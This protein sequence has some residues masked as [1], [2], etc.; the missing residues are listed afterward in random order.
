MQWSVQNKLTL[1]F[2]KTK[3]MIFHGPGP[4]CFIVPPPPVGIECVTSFKLLGVYL[5]ST[6]SMENHVN[7]FFC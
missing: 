1:N 2:T 7:L 5:A 4:C 6:L 3:E